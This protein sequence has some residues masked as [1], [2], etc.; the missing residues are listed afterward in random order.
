MKNLTVLFTSCG[1]EAFEGAL[2]SMR[3]NGERNIRVIGADA[4]KVSHGLYMADAAYLVPRDTDPQY[5]RTIADI[6]KKEKVDVIYPLASGGQSI[7]YGYE[8][9]LG[10]PIL[11]QPREGLE[12][13]DNKFLL[14]KFA[15]KHN[16]GAPDVFEVATWDDIQ[17]AALAVGF[18][19]KPFVLKRHKSSGAK[20]LKIIYNTLD[21]MERFMSRENQHMSIEELKFHILKLQKWP[22]MHVAE[23]LP[24][25]EYSVDVLCKEKRVYATIVRKRYSAIGGSSKVAE[26]VDEEDLKMLSINL[27][28][29]LKLTYVVNLQWRRDAKGTPKIME[30]NP[31]IPATIHQTIKA[32]VNM[33][34]LAVKLALNEEITIPKEQLGTMVIKYYGSVFIQKVDLLTPFTQT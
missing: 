17:K 28:Q 26:V 12:I 21:P 14:C 1:H 10:I 2:D 15:R 6:C 30:I 27:A 3:T 23:Y 9:A 25:N 24:G 32:G 29:A 20:G 33:P 34:Y 22:Q 18:P 11:V 4:N 19:E 13:A 8:N 7:F 31:R 16:I 5:I